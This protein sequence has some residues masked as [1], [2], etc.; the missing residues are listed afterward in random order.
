MTGGRRALWRAVLAFLSVCGVVLLHFAIVGRVA[1]ALGAALSLVPAALL[2]AW[3][4][5]RTR[6]R[7]WAIAA[8]VLVALALWRGWAGLER[9]F[10]SVFYAEHAGSNL[11]LAF[12]FGRTLAAGREPLCTRFARILHGGTLPPGVA[13]YTRRLTAAWTIFFIALC[14][15]SSALYFGGWLEAWSLL[16]TVLSPLLL[17]LMFAGEYAVRI[18]SLPEVERVGFLGGIRAFSRHFAAAPAQ[19]R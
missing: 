14:A 8:I 12:V 1:P 15:L 17:A 13:G 2:A 18:R 19:G 11:A 7:E 6:H 4:A 10:P 16:A 5:R 3:L 9:V